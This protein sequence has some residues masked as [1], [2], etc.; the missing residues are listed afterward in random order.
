MKMI[1]KNPDGIPKDFR[2]YIE[3]HK[4]ELGLPEIIAIW[5]IIIAT[6]LAF[7]TLV[8]TVTIGIIGFIFQITVPEVELLARISQIQYKWLQSTIL[9][10]LSSLPWIV[11]LTSSVSAFIVILGKDRLRS[12]VLKTLSSFAAAGIIITLLHLQSINITTSYHFDLLSKTQSSQMEVI[13]DMSEELAERESDISSIKKDISSL[14]SSITSLENLIPTPTPTQEIG[15]LPVLEETFSNNSRGWFYY[16]DFYNGFH[17]IIPD[18]GLLEY[19]LD[20]PTKEGEEDKICVHQ[21]DFPI[22][23]F[24]DFNLNMKIYVDGAINQDESFYGVKLRSNSRGE[25]YLILFNSQGKYRFVFVDANEVYTIIF[26]KRSE[27]I[28]RGLGAEN[29]NNIE[30]IADGNKIEIVVNSKSVEIIELDNVFEVPEKRLLE[31]GELSF[32]LQSKFNPTFNIKIDEIYV[33]IDQP[34][35]E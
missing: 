8:I 24:A 20:C 11:I 23:E 13:E 34:N 7:W 22:D 2:K 9:F 5:G 28:V 19:Q 25:Y 3:D 30:L 1:F 33:S 32:H 15:R 21:L 16:A 10:L 31:A 6:R 26:E 14:E 12:N 4:D 29:P 35:N 27:E 17:K 18:P